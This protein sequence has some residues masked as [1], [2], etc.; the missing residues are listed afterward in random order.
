MQL[1]KL[2]PRRWVLGLGGVVI[3]LI[4]IVLAV[5]WYYSDAIEEGGLKVKH[6][7]NKYD[8]QVLKVEDDLITLRLP[9]GKDPQEE[10]GTMGI[11]WPDGYSR[12]GE[13]VKI[14]GDE[15]IRKYEQIEG[16]LSEGD[17][18]RFDSFAFPADPERAHG[19]A[20]EEITFPSPLGD[21]PAWLVAS[22]D[23]T[24][25]IFV[26]GKGSS[27]REALR[28][29]PVVQGAGLPSLVITY[30]NDVGAAEDPSGRYQYGRTEWED[31][32]AAASYALANG[33]NDLLLVGY[34]MGGGIVASFLYRS[35]LADRV[36]GAVLD[37]P[38]LDFETIVDWES[39]KRDLPGFLTSVAKRI[40]SF[41]FDVNWGEL[42]YL[43]R[44]D[45]ISVPILLFH[46]DAD[47]TI[48]VSVSKT[49]NEKHPD[50]V[51]YVPFQGARHVRSWNMDPERYEAAVLEFV[52]RVAR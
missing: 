52:S 38:M 1:F 33:A 44:S 6:E 10:S 45:E 34:S 25:V 9:T 36:V 49:L 16:N 22:A 21:S 8:V 7:P 30:R 26:H 31:L 5:G 3:L 29:L 17:R 19:I 20:F 4:G 37:S 35:P 32:Q 50:L 15:V 28:T 51:T 48:P 12:V 24:W 18:V 27:R 47:E 13:I 46:G 23:D 42:D 14:R 11:E 39:D 41:R 2:T 40:T 43:S